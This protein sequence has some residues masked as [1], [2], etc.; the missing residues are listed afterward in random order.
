MGRRIITIQ[1]NRTDSSG[2]AVD[3]YF[4]KVI[5][6]IP[7]DIVGGWVAVTG[8]IKSADNVPTNLLLW[9]AFGAGIILT[10]LWTLKQTSEPGKK[11]AKTQIIISTF[12]F[13]VWVFA[14]G[15]P[16]ATLEFYR[17]LYGS[18]MLIFY[19][20]GIGLVTPTEK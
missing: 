6:Y 10:L 12:S 2:A 7:S 5:K 1:Y 15:G 18:L 13:A 11:T 19:S 20:L 14:L 3:G 8:L 17:P 16:F 9:I 4:D